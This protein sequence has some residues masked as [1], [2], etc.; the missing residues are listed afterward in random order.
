MTFS[1]NDA[2]L[3]L[4]SIDECDR[5][6]IRYEIRTRSDDINTHSDSVNGNEDK[7]ANASRFNSGEFKLKLVSNNI[8][9]RISRALYAEITERFFSESRARARNRRRADS[10]TCLLLD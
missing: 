8:P 5:S 7:T 10:L 1:S 4:T 6:E 2:E 3:T 9:I